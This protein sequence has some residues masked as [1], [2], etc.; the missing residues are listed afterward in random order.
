MKKI[1]I[2][3]SGM[4]CSFIGLHAGITF[5]GSGSAF[6]ASGGQITLAQSLPVIDGTF[7]VT[8]DSSFSGTVTG[9]RATI[10]VDDG[11]T[12][13][14]MKLTGQYDTN[15]GAVTLATSGDVV[16]L[17][18]GKTKA[19]VSVVQ[20]GTIQGSG[21]FGDTISVASGKVATVALHKTLNVAINNNGTVRLASDLSL[22]D[23]VWFTGN[24]GTLDGAGHTITLGTN[25]LNINQE[26][27]W[28]NLAVILQSPVQVTKKITLA[29]DVLLEGN[30]NEITLSDGSAVCDMN[31]KVLH[32]TDIT[33]KNIRSNLVS[34]AGS[35]SMTNTTFSDDT[36][37]SFVVNN[38]AKATPIGDTITGGSFFKQNV[39]WES[40]ATIT[41][42]G[43]SFLVDGATWTSGAV[44]SD[45]TDIVMNGNGFAFNLENGSINPNGNDVYFH[46]ITLSGMKAGSLAASGRYHFLNTT[47][48]NELSPYPA[49]VINGRNGSSSQVAAQ[50]TVASGDLFNGDVTWANNVEVE[51]LNNIALGQ[52]TEWR[53]E[54]DARIDG[55]NK[56]LDLSA[57][58]AKLKIGNGKTLTLS[59]LVLKGWGGS[60]GE[61]QA[62]GGQISYLGGSSEMS[63]GRLILNNVTIVMDGD[64]TLAPNSGD[65]EYITVE[66]ETTFITDDYM[67]DASGTSA[68]NVI[69]DVVVTYD[70]KGKADKGNVTFGTS[71]TGG[72]SIC[73]RASRVTGGLQYD[74]SN[75]DLSQ[76]Q[77]LYHADGL[78]A[79]NTATIATG[80][81]ALVF[82]GHG[83]AFIMGSK[84]DGAAT[85]ELIKVTGNGGATT[86]NLVLDGLKSEY[87]DGSLA[88]GDKTSLF[89]KEN[90]VLTRV[91]TFEDTK[92]GTNVL[93]LG[94]SELDLG[95][96]G[97][98]V[99]NANSG[100]QLTIANG[101]LTGVT[102]ALL[103]PTSSNIAITLDNLDLVLSGD[104]T[105]NNAAL[106]VQGDCRLTGT[107]DY[108]FTNSSSLPLSLKKGSRLTID[109]GMTYAASGS[110]EIV[111][112]SRNAT[113]ALEGATLDSSAATNGL[114]LTHGSLSID[115]TSILNGDFSIG[116]SVESG[117]ELDLDV[118]PA[119]LVKLTNGRLTYKNP[120]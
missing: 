38:C 30:G 89:V 63:G 84:P 8:K 15:S 57:N 19:G 9:T 32:L 86:R 99:V 104:T 102:G 91:Y 31:S 108:R 118:K 106:H 21:T 6:V 26:Q 105:F 16:T 43:D 111:F 25:P 34:N 93:D 109:A 2:I 70:T 59:N 41:L 60:N 73:P 71:F 103:N 54:N 23:D 96:Y 20:D 120:S 4:L 66:G 112:D 116:G 62:A 87:I 28:K 5:G 94:G 47:V 35:F 36:H 80:E 58:G 119:A 117:E 95:G 14:T 46:D 75:K 45:G 98:K 22:A 13:V 72:G 110:H 12:Q 90:D 115:S 29:S 3:L 100:S 74:A 65:K 114:S 7:R 101:R 107:G 78:I 18:S 68:Q 40:D 55:K 69:D 42:L 85:S 83:R 79:G 56:I 39:R 53:F 17:Q 97:I 77:F 44:E 10:E 76:S 51:L 88:F 61:G 11:T 113:L 81:S 1:Q 27:I 49:I 64:V 92:A 82:N 24:G 50:V 52:G 37:G 48:F 33:L 67:F